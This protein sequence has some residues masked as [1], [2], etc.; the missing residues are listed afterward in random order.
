MK[1]KLI[2][3]TEYDVLYARRWYVYLQRAGICSEI[4]RGMRRRLRHEGKQAIREG[5]EP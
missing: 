1:Q 2:N 5:R 4:K 3:G